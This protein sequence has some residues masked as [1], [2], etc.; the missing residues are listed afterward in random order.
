M[1]CSVLSIGNPATSRT[2]TALTGYGYALCMLTMKVV[3]SFRSSSSWRS[4]VRRTST[5]R[6]H[7]QA[8]SIDSF[9]L[10]VSVLFSPGKAHA[11]RILG[12]GM[13]EK[14]KDI[15]LKSCLSPPL[16]KNGEAGLVDC[17]MCW[18]HCE[19]LCGCLAYWRRTECEQ[20]FLDAPRGPY[21]PRARLFP[22][23]LLSLYLVTDN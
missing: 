20:V 7:P 17:L 14:H 21:C 13:G 12:L 16:L 4:V 11:L 22:L 1:P 23:P 10:V 18:F 19:V 15:R 5:F 9:L 3:L 2:L 8:F 6:V